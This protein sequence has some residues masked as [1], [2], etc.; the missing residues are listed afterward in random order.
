MDRSGA[1]NILQTV[2]FLIIL[3]FGLYFLN[4][5]S[6]DPATDSKIIINNLE[7]GKY[8]IHGDASD[9]ALPENSL[10]SKVLMAG[11]APALLKKIGAIET[12]E[13]GSLKENYSLPMIMPVSGNIRI[14][15]GFG[16][17]RDP[18]TGQPAFHNGI[19]IPVRTGSPVIATGGGYIAE[20]GLDNLLGK[21]III[22]HQDDYQSIYGHLSSIKVDQDQIVKSGEI[23]GLSGTTG[24]STNPHLHYQINYKGRPVDPVKTKKQLDNVRLVLR[25]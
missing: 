11:L 1:E 10:V 21:Y 24:R 8:G 5:P 3:I 15:S 7:S 16:V 23:I 12:I 14:S 2:F 25:D 13:E 20:T 6:A 19:D 4:N 22:N 17:R 18:F 9:P